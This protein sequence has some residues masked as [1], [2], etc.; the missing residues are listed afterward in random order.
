MALDTAL[1]ALLSCHSIY[2]WKIAAEGENPTVILRLRPET[3]LSSSRSGV[4]ADTVAFR[5]KTPCQLNRD[6]RR[7]EEF[8]QKKVNVENIYDAESTNKTEN[9]EKHE[10]NTETIHKPP[11]ENY[12]K[13]GDSVD[14]V[15]LHTSTDTTTNSAELHTRDEREE[16]AICDECVAREGSGMETDSESDIENNTATKVSETGGKQP[17]VDAARELVKNAERLRFNQDLLRQEDRNNSFNRVVFDRRCREA[18][19]LLCCS[20]D[21]M[22]TIDIESGQTNFLLRDPGKMHLDFW[23]FWPDI[24]RDGPYKDMIAKTRIEMREILK[25]IREM[26]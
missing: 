26:I 24:D 6:R 1:K 3:Q 16:T 20:N 9:T 8:R 4:R 14:R 22:A 25:R 19:Y 7:A 13:R 5:R 17:I 21:V 12:N 11:S 10:L 15:G 18:P 23:H 2:S